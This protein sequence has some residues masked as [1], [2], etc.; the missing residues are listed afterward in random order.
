[1]QRVEEEVNNRKFARMRNPFLPEPTTKKPLGTRLVSSSP[2]AATATVTASTAAAKVVPSAVSASAS[3]PVSDSVPL[4]GIQV[5]ADRVGKSVG[6]TGNKLVLNKHKIDQA[7]SI[8]AASK[9]MQ[10][11]SSSSFSS[12]SSP[13]RSENASRKGETKVK[14]EVKHVEDKKTSEGKAAIVANSTRRARKNTSAPLRSRSR[15]NRQRKS[16]TLF[17]AGILG[18]KRGKSNEYFGGDSTVVSATND[19]DD[20]EDEDEHTAA[21]EDSGRDD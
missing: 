17:S 18:R 10:D 5:L 12:S 20:D 2:P 7:T 19:S 14:G 13:S 4:S 8:A 11:S 9:Q 16:H 6:R 3:A 1:V 21:E 15:A